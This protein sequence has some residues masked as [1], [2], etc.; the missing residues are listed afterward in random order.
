M[1]FKSKFLLVVLVAIIST[2]VFLALGENTNNI[3]TS[4]SFAETQ[5]FS[6]REIKL[7]PANKAE[8]ISNLAQAKVKRKVV[9]DGLTFEELGDKLNLSMRGIIAGQGHYFAARSLELGIDPYMALAIVLQETG[10]E[11]ECSYLTKACFNIGGQK[12]KPACS[13]GY[14][15]FNSLKEGI[16]GYLYNL[17]NNY[18]SKGL[19]TPETI[20]SV[21][22]ESPVWHL[23][24]RDYMYKIASR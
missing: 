16:D 23:K 14:R 18:V 19:T 13:G 15:R 1:N 10:C 22:A 6:K 4:V 7:E 11:W 8:I 17:Y 5:V 2:F 24:V 20:N 9:F 12:G 3:L 21:Y